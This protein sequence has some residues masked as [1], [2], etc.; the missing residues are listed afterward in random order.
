MLN[1]QHPRIRKT[2]YMVGW[3]SET[4]IRLAISQVINIFYF[5]YIFLKE[6]PC[7]LFST[8][9]ELAIAPFYMF[10]LFGG[11]GRVF[12]DTATKPVT[13]SKT[14]RLIYPACDVLLVQWPELA[15]KLGHKTKYWGRVI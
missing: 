7:I 8:G 14:A 5:I 4:G 10:R 6:R 9:A 2:Y 12:L 1:F 11:K 3:G 13:L 15:G